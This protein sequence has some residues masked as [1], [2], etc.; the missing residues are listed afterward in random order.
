MIALI[1]LVVAQYAETANH[2]EG[3]P[4][5]ESQSQLSLRRPLLYPHYERNWGGLSISGS[6]L[7]NIN[8]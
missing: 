8:Q 1:A 5:N 6:F 4:S 2:P 3:G 7:F